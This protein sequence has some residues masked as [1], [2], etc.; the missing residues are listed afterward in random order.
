MG[1]V[2]FDK[3]VPRL[4]CCRKPRVDRCRLDDDFGRLLDLIGLLL[5]RSIDRAI[6]RRV[7]RAI[8]R[9]IDRRVDRRVDRLD[10]LDRL[11]KRG[12]Q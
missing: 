5:P 6:D 8:G 2:V 11:Q 10:R 7:G 9:A 3:A 1:L 4:I 12:R